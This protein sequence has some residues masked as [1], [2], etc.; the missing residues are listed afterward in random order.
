MLK[1]WRAI[2]SLAVTLGWALASAGEPA[3]HVDPSP[4]AV[5]LDQLLRLPQDNDP[6]VNR[7][8]G[9]HGRKDWETMF[10]SARGEL[11]TAERGLAESQR[12]LE[13]LASKSDNWKLAAPGAAS[14]TA[15][16]SP[17]SYRLSQEIRGGR[18]RVELAERRLLEL[19]IEANLAAVPAEWRSLEPDPTASA[20]G[21]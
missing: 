13:S 9:G 7:E 18:E 14:Q 20:P 3:E 17:L 12:Q 1:S 8:L 10:A 21:S 6:V 5:G 2:G 16:N 11:R 15:E 19:E 4:P